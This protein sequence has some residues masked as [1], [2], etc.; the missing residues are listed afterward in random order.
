[1]NPRLLIGSTLIALLLMACGAKAMHPDNPY[2]TFTLPDG[3]KLLG[4]ASFGDGMHFEGVYELPNKQAVYVIIFVLEY[5]KGEEAQTSW[6]NTGYIARDEFGVSCIF[7]GKTRH[8]ATGEVAT[9][10]VQHI[11]QAEMCVEDRA[12]GETWEYDEGV[13]GAILDSYEPK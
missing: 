9:G 13:V 3:A 12:T 4:Q 11:I 2:W 5:S 6:E 10:Q 8:L 7:L 1:M